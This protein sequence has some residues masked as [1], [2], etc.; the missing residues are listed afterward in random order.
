[1]KIIQ[2]VVKI[3]VKSRVYKR[4]KEKDTVRSIVGNI[5]E[6]V[7]KRMSRKFKNKKK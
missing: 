3:V 2:C 1:M 6:I 4:E 5:K 7:A